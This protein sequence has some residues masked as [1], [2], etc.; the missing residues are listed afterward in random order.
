M[1]TIALA[2]LLGLALLATSCGGDDSDDE[3]ATVPTGVVAIVGDD[4]LSRANF[5]RALARWQE[6]GESAQSAELRDRARTEVMESLIETEW[7]R[8]EAARLGVGLSDAEAKRLF[9]QTKLED[10]GGNEKRYQKTIKQ[11][12]L[13]ETE[14]LQIFV[15]SELSERLQEAVT[16]GLP[17]KKRDAAIA[18]ISSQLRTRYLTATVCAADLRTVSCSNAAPDAAAPGTGT[19]GGA[20]GTA[21]PAGTSAESGTGTAAPADTGAESGTGTGGA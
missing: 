10:F 19:G 17:A 6:N 16:Q 13:D 14:A 7:T 4:E 1:R 11:L 21:A 18:G 15:G 2:L 8:Q 12:D 3:N 20:G 5:Q 9:E